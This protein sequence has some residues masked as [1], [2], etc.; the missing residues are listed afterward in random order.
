MGDNSGQQT[1]LIYVIIAVFAIYA[2]APL[3]EQKS[4]F[5]LKY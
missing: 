2:L 1:S 3:L 5:S 4:N